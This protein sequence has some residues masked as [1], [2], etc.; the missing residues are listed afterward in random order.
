[1]SL[2]SKKVNEMVDLRSERLK[3]RWKENREEML[4]YARMANEASPMSK[5]GHKKSEEH[6]RKISESHKGL[7]SSRK[8]KTYEEIY[9]IEG[10]K[11]VKVKQDAYWTKEHRAEI[12]A[13]NKQLY[14]SGV[15]FCQGW[16]KGLTC[17]TDE[18][19]KKNHE[20]IN[21]TLR[22]LRL[23]KTWEEI[24]GIEKG[25]EMRYQNYLNALARPE[26]FNEKISQ[27]M[28]T[29]FTPEERKTRAQK[30]GLYSAKYGKKKDTKIEL[31]LQFGLKR[32]GISFDTQFII[33]KTCTIDI[34]PKNSKIAVFADG[35]YWHNLPE[36]IEKDKWVNQKLVQNGWKVLRFW[37]HEINQNLDFCID[38]IL[39]Q[40]NALKE[41][42]QYN[43]EPK[44][45][46]TL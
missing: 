17:E 27:T 37:E 36:R 11:E 2:F 32:K 1:M 16:N 7:P 29:K 39:E 41:E 10:A 21:V 4:T 18:R 45:F 8:G 31:S 6:K 25:S 46:T 5:K 43:G 12:G 14:E 28:L 3:K 33:P 34:V 13:Y 22:K 9:G 38:K 40:Y 30:A 15:K 26:E 42:S 44:L 24:Y 19:V 20:K 23:G 35:D